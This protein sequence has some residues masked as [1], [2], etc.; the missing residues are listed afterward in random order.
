MYV[1]FGV[2]FARHIYVQ[3]I[4]SS[5]MVAEWPPF[6]KILPRLTVCS[7]CYMSICNFVCHSRAGVLF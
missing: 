7:L 2:V 5:V 6:E 1:S 4:L 3:I